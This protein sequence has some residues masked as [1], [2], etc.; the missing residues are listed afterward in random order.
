MTTP[1]KPSDFVRLPMEALEP[2]C[3]ARNARLFCSP[4]LRAALEALFDSPAGFL[5]I[6]VP[7]GESGDPVWTLA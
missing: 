7:G 4:T 1:L 5:A 3:A 6:V 2:V